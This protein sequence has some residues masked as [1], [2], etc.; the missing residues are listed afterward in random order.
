MDIGQILG[1]IGAGVGA[2]AINTMVGSGSLVS[3]P[4]LLAFGYPPV[5]A[6]VTNTV[7][8]VPGSITGAWGYRRELAGQRNR[9]ISFG[10]ASLLGAIIGALL[11]L[12]LDPSVFNAVVPVIIALAIVLVLLQPWLNRVL[13]RRRMAAGGDGASTDATDFGRGALIGTAIGVFLSGIYGGYFSAAQGIL[14]LA[15]LG[16][17]L[18]E[19]LQRVNAL[20]NVLQMLVNIVAAIVFIIVYDIEWGAV[21]LMAIGTLIGGQVGAII[22]RRMPAWALRTIIVIVGVVAIFMLLNR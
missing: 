21:G 12:K 13:T 16:L 11:L 14:L 10:I 6:N 8:L 4:V 22:G 1:I 18:P 2:G 15:V 9:I 3:F 7:G 5:S 19:S 17:G 20:K